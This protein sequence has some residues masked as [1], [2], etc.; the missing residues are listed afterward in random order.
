M[1][2]ALLFIEKPYYRN[3]LKKDHT[4]PFRRGHGAI[5]MVTLLMLCKKIGVVYVNINTLTAD[6]DLL[7]DHFGQSEYNFARVAVLMTALHSSIW[8][9]TMFGNIMACSCCSGDIDYSDDSD[10]SDDPDDEDMFPG[11]SARSYEP[12][13][14]LG[15]SRPASPGLRPVSV[16]DVDSE[17]DP[18]PEPEPELELAPARPWSA[19]L[20]S[21]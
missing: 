19:S 20:T 15:L 18:D 9:P 11:N 6:C 14:S 16:A 5:D 3:L 12:V 21:V 4:S 8:F 17:P 2:P 10:D 1:I 13:H 7:K